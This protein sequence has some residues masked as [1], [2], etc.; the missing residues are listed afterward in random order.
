[1]KRKEK[2]KVQLYFDN[3]FHTET[4]EEE[5]ELE[6]KDLSNKMVIKKIEE[7]YKLRN[8][9]SIEKIFRNDKCIFDFYQQLK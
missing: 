1:M 9:V 2:I 4:Q 8:S 7:I 3:Q 6:S 5:F